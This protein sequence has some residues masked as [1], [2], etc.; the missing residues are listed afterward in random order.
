MNECA[1]EHF[2]S[3][4]CIGGDHSDHGSHVRHD[5]A[6]A[7]CHA[8][9]GDR[10]SSQRRILAHVADRTLLGIGI[11]GHDRACSIASRF[12]RHGFVKLWHGRFEWCRVEQL[13]DH[14]G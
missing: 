9:E 4:R 2:G 7:L 3:K 12:T 10:G 6:R 5:H 11:G 13:T 8:A 14:T 1:A